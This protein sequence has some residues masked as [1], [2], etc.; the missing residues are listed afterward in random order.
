VPSLDA[1]LGSGSDV[2]GVVTNPDRPAG[3][4]LDPRPSPV[5]RRATDAGLC[6]LQPARARAPEVRT[7]LEDIAPDVAVVVAYGSI[8]P[9]ELLQV[10]PLGFVNLHFSLLPRYR[11]AAPVQHALID[12]AT[13][14]GV[15]IMVLTAGMDEG[16]LLAAEEVR[17][18]PD[19]TAGTLGARMA[20][21]GA[22]LLVPT[23][24]RY[25]SGE[26]V[27]TEQDHDRATYAPRIRGD[28]ARIDWI[29]PAAA[30]R[31]FVRALNPEPGAWTTLRGTRLKVHRAAVSAPA[32]LAPGE[33]SSGAELVAGT[34][35]GALVLLKVQLAGRRAMSGAELA[36][37]L[38][39]SPGEKLA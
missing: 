2:A 33:L 28:D 26:L 30:I 39:L 38:R 5:K 27:P 23:L 1:L 15:S 31:N 34:G 32:R 13:T 9:A 22:G 17:V 24:E 29:R 36:R 35:A 37:G 14:T 8:L 21:L 7:W 3:R 16:P 10:P 25:A 12:G 20:A 19:D 4:G 6:V 18:S 11:G